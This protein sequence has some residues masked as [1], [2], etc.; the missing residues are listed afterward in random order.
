MLFEW[1]GTLSKNPASLQAKMGGRWLTAEY[2]LGDLLIF[3]MRTIHASLDNQSNRIRIS[4]DT[5]YQLAS[6]P[7]DERYA[8]EDSTPY[9]RDF[10]KGRIC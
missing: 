6:D 9:A 2:E 1:D 10:K 5:R 8:R 4:A 7:I 3:S